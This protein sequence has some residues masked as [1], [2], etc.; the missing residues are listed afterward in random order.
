[1]RLKFTSVFVDDQDK[2]L[3]FY[4]EILG[5]AKKTDISVG[6]YRWLTV[7]SPEEPEGTELLLELTTTQLLRHFKEPFMIKGYQ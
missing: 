3:K 4:T 6:E 7:V 2:A 5:F 1:M